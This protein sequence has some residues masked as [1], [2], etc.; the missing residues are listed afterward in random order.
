MGVCLCVTQAILYQ[1]SVLVTQLVTHCVD[2]QPVS[3]RLLVG[4]A[5]EHKP[6]ATHDCTHTAEH[7]S[8]AVPPMR[9]KRH[10]SAVCHLLSAQLHNE[11][12]SRSAPPLD[13]SSLPEITNINTSC[14]PL[15]QAAATTRSTQHLLRLLRKGPECNL[16]HC[17]ELLLHV[18]VSTSCQH[19]RVQLQ[20]LSCCILSSCCCLIARPITLK[21][22]IINI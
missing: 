3:M 11:Y 5:Q 18:A 16:L 22:C 2:Q 6:T 15:K 12:E 7:R 21:R 8:V 17:A 19:L 13:S 10:T 4:Q 14:Y 1:P 9:P 20:V